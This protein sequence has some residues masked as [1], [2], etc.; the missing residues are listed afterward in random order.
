MGFLTSMQLLMSLQIVLSSK[1]L[2]TCGAS[3]GTLACMPPVMRF[4]VVWAR[5]CLEA[6]WEGALVEGA[7]AGLERVPELA[8]G[9]FLIDASLSIRKLE[10][11]DGYF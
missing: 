1:C 6:V 5:E 7:L 10:V 2:G 11:I 9:D 4:E 3:E 8:V